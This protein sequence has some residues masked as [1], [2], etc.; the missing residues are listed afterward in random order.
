[1]VQ[2]PSPYTAF[3][4]EY[5][6][7]YLN[8]FFREMQILGNSTEYQMVV[9][10]LRQ[11]NVYHMTPES[12]DTQVEQIMMDGLV[13]L[14][15]HRTKRYS[16]FAHCHNFVDKIDQDTMI[17][18]VVAQDL[19]T[20]KKFREVQKDNVDHKITG[21]LLGYPECC[22]LAFNEYFKTSYDPIW[23]PSLA[24]EGSYMDKNGVLH[25]PH[26]NPKIL[27]HLR[28]YGLRI[29]PW[30][31]CNF[32]CEESGKRADI[33]FNLMKSLNEDLAIKLLTH[34]NIRNT[35][36]DLYNAQINTNIPGCGFGVAASYYTP[37]RRIIV[38]GD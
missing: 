24:T 3:I 18:G 8:D 7:S 26:Y 12:F 21:E 23:E 35:T 17:Y 10:G 5:E 37:E 13:F 32:L 16:G 38:V 31:P 29:T 19:E 4:F 28:Y 34:L 1:M 2:A 15:I 6:K 25:V 14:P 20:A 36:W 30:F 9:K 27:Q 11:V 33:W 22:G